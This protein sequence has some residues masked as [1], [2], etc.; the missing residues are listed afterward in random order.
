MTN[1]VAKARG[2]SG[3]K[4]W[5]I[6]VAA[7]VVVLI[8][9]VVAVVSTK[10]STKKTPTGTAAT[11]VVHQVTN[12]PASVAASVGVGTGQATPT[13]PTGLTALTKDGKPE[14]L[15]VGAEYCPYCA[16][17]RWAMVEALSRF[18][19][20]SNLKLTHSSSSDVFPDTPTFT[21]HG[22]TY[23]SPHLTFTPVELSTNQPDGNGGYTPLDTLTTEQQDIVTRFSQQ[24]SIPFMDI[25]GKFI[26]SGVTYDPKVLQG[27]TA[28]EIA[29]AMQDPTTD[30]AKGAIG[31]ANS[32]TAMICKT[33]GNQPAKVCSTPTITAIQ[34]TL[35]S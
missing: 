31:S 24:G 34:K 22:A 11:S 16:T 8:A 21:F 10:S 15:Y 20:F 1:T 13:V 4:A 6:G 9:L 5:I 2:G 29:A 7:L 25:G 35:P 3:S 23:T 27:K 28:E 18:G 19:T 12:V 17:E 30:I 32:L 14:L 26:L 33:T